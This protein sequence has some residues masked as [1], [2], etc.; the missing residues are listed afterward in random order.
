MHLLPSLCTLRLVEKPIYLVDLDVS[1]G[2]SRR[3]HTSDRME[4]VFSA[5]ACIE[6]S[7]LRQ[8]VGPTQLS[9]TTLSK[10]DVAI[11]GCGCNS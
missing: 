10:E 5:Q 6:A 2:S 4:G 9:C 8:E 3:F 7:H 1:I 11:E